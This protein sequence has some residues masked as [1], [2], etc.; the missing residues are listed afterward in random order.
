[1]WRL[2]HV[3][4]G[5]SCYSSTPSPCLACKI[6]HDIAAVLAEQTLGNVRVDV[7]CNCG[8]GHAHSA[9]HSTQVTQQ[10][11]A[12]YAIGKVSKQS[13]DNTAFRNVGQEVV[14]DAQPQSIAG[15]LRSQDTLPCTA[16]PAVS[17]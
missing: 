14:W 10:D 2:L 6:G 4:F 12:I 15:S 13:T 11:E 8:R 1:M 7:I 16:S 9:W 5:A 17:L 3:R